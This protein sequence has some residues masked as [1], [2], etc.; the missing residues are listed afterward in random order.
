MSEGV[1][2]MMGRTGR[3]ALRAQTTTL[4]AVL[5][6]LPTAALA[7]DPVTRGDLPYLPEYCADH[8][9]LKQISGRSGGRDWARVFGDNNWTHMSHYCYGLNNLNHAVREARDKTRSNYLAGVAIG[10]INYVLSHGDPAHWPLTSEA[11]MNIA[12]AQV[13]Q[14][15][16]A[17]AG[18]SLEKAILANPKFV[19]AYVVLYEMHLN[20]NNKTAALQ[21]IEEGL[22]QVPDSKHLASR[23]QTQTGKAFVPP[24]EAIKP[25]EQAKAEQAAQ[26]AAPAAQAEQKS[27]TNIGNGGLIGN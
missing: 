18:G 25:V 8:P 7:W 19:P 13:I 17:Q 15:Q 5:A 14:G 22:K 1:M 11:Y 26:E 12:R 27:D 16:A 6:V 9:G 20:N 2:N 23:Y 10:E 4:L 3:F 21:V 24:P